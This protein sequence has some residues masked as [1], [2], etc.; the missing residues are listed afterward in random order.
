MEKMDK[1]VNGR[2]INKDSAQWYEDEQR[3]RREEE[4][5]QAESEERGQDPEGPKVKGTQE[6][7]S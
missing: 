6:G 3:V 2:G 4:G 1:E 5:S 7:P